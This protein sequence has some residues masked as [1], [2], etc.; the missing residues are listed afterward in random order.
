M[1]E[2]TAENFVKNFLKWLSANMKNIFKKD[3]KTM[4]DWVKKEKTAKE[5]SAIAVGWGE[6]SLYSIESPVVPKVI[7]DKFKFYWRIILKILKKYNT[8]RI[9]AQLCYS[10]FCENTISNHISFMR[11]IKKWIFF[12]N[13]NTQNVTSR[14]ILSPSL[15]T[16]I[17]KYDEEEKQSEDLE[18]QRCYSGYSTDHQFSDS[19]DSSDSDSD[20]GSRTSTSTLS[21]SSGSYESDRHPPN[22]IPPGDY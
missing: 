4:I 18:L 21:G 20:S 2:A 5:N 22:R 19:S 10:P 11:Q 9:Q 16:K 8:L 15:I 13:H 14:E 12:L 1:E 17:L 3:T 6:Q 7:S